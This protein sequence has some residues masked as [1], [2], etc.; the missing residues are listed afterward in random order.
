MPNNIII[1]ASGDKLTPEYVKCFRTNSILNSLNEIGLDTDGKC[2]S[3]VNVTFMTDNPVSGNIY[4]YAENDIVFEETFEN[5]MKSFALALSLD[6]ME[7]IDKLRIT[8]N[9]G[10]DILLNILF[11]YTEDKC[12]SRVSIFVFGDDEIDVKCCTDNAPAPNWLND[13]AVSQNG[14]IVIADDIINVI[15]DYYL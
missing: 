15:G 5:N 8:T 4:G 13:V 3:I 9:T 12:Y 2:V 6:E 11:E 1:D 10:L 14:K 7:K